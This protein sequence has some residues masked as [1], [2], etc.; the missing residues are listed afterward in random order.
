MAPLKKL[1]L[2]SAVAVLAILLNGCATQGTGVSGVDSPM[3]SA[4]EP[5]AVREPVPVV[6]QAP[7][8]QALQEESE[9][10]PASPPVPTFTPK[11]EIETGRVHLSKADMEFARTRLEEYENR[12]ASW[13]KLEEKPQ[14]GELAEELAGHGAECTRKLEQLISR[15]GLLLKIMDPA[16][17]VSQGDAASTGLQK[18]AQL[19]I[20]FLESRCAELLA[21]T[22]SLPEEEAPETEPQATLAAAK[23]DIARKLEQGA[24]SEV[25]MAYGLLARDFPGQVVSPATR[26][27]YVLALRYTGQVEAAARNLQNMLTADGP[28][29][30][31]LSLEGETADLLLAAGDPAAAARFYQHVI[32]RFEE[33]QAERTWAEE[34][35]AFLQASELDSPE[36]L[37]Y[38]KLLREFLTSDYRFDGARLNEAIHAFTIEYTGSPAAVSALRLKTFTLE[39]VKAWFSSKLSTAYS[40]VEENDFAGATQVLEGMNEY[41]LPAELQAVL[42]QTYYA[43]AQAELRED[44]NRRRLEEMELTRQWEAAVNLLD[45]QQFDPA[46]AAFAALQETAYGEE[47]LAK[48][49]EAANRAAGRM[50]KEAAALFIRAGKTPDPEEKKKLLLS[51]HRLLHDIVARYPQSDL[52]GKVHQNITIL[53]EQIERIDPTLLEQIEQEIPAAGAGSPPGARAADQLP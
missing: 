33:S 51:S 5:Q 39:K 11:K 47:A 48:I 44:E 40:L 25:L 10:V 49:T 26:L 35:L 31:P 12:Y 20:A 24:Y 22:L 30:E 9:P 17:G 38:T 43:I 23:K 16:G 28:F 45:S 19:D 41:Y 1:T 46:I 32:T 3:S 4:P 14:E 15:Y 37:A 27:H 6:V 29:S 21:L 36:M 2:M 53:E 50:R 34:Q 52:L 18:I 42:Q 13:L 7:A 8:I